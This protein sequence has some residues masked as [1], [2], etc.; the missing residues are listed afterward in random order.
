LANSFFCNIIGWT[1]LGACLGWS[2][3]HCIGS[4]RPWEEQNYHKRHQQGF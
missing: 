1:C 4:M 2:Y 3:Y